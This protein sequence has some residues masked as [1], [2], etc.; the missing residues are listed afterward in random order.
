M[1]ARGGQRAPRPTQLAAIGTAPTS[2]LKDCCHQ[3]SL[4]P[5]PLPGP[6]RSPQHCPEQ[7]LVHPRLQSGAGGR[8]DGSLAAGGRAV[9]ACEAR[10]GSATPHG[11]RTK[12]LSVTALA[13]AVQAQV[14]GS[15]PGVQVEPRPP[16]Q[17]MQELQQPHSPSRWNRMV[18]TP[19]PQQTRDERKI[20]DVGR[21]DVARQ[22][23]PV[24]PLL[25]ASARQHGSMAG[26]R[27]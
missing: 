13:V 24:L 20:S 27:A 22:P 21:W 25:D 3:P 1:G 5:H 16:R 26:P 14:G 9:A 4:T 11:A 12:P 2:R 23:A 17:P 15:L 19:L 18:S 8:R 6:P 7:S 10:R